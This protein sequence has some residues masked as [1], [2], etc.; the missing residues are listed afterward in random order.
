MNVKYKERED[1]KE[2]HKTKWDTVR[3]CKGICTSDTHR[4]R[5][6]YE[7][8][9]D[10]QREEKWNNICE[11][12]REGSFIMKLKLV[13]EHKKSQKTFSGFSNPFLRRLTFT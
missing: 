9:K 13:A 10:S 1:L 3:N 7:C 6:M 5:I 12:E 4:G 2:I 11:R 8:E